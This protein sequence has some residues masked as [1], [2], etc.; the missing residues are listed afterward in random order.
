MVPAKP[1]VTSTSTEPSAP[2][3]LT[4]P[5]ALT[6]TGLTASALRT[7]VEPLVQVNEPVLHSSRVAASLA[8]N[9]TVNDADSPCARD[10]TDGWTLTSTPGM[11]WTDAW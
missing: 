1:D 5:G 3:P 2:E 11:P 4:S 10:S 7:A 6:P 9:V 8:V